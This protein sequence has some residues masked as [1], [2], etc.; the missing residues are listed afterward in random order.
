M[1]SV[2]KSVSVVLFAAAMLFS[3]VACSIS[4]KTP[5]NDKN[6]TPSDS[7][8]SVNPPVGQ[9]ESPS[10]PTPPPT[11]SSTLVPDAALISYSI[12][13][14][15]A[16]DS[17]MLSSEVSAALA[18]TRGLLRNKASVTLPKDAKTMASTFRAFE[19]G[20]TDFE[21][22]DNKVIAIQ[23]VKDGDCGPNSRWV[24]KINDVEVANA[25]LDT[26]ALNSG[27]VILWVYVIG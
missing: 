22:A 20:G 21:V 14:R 17:G 24:L 23:G 19:V 8:A 12:D 7:P 4:E 26:V 1:K 13:A 27:D 3:S 10:A 9:S 16:Y 15:A 18:E 5:N 2:F 11:S 25:N 6:S